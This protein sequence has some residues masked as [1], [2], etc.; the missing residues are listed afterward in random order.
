MISVLPYLIFDFNLIYPLFVLFDCR[1]Y[2]T[3]QIFCPR[4]YLSLLLNLIVMYTLTQNIHPLLV[5]FDCH[6][7]F[8]DLIFR[9]QLYLSSPPWLDCHVYLNPIHPLLVKFDCCVYFNRYSSLPVHFSSTWLFSLSALTVNCYIILSK[10]V[11][12]VIPCHSF[13]LVNGII[14]MDSCQ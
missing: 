8:T 1:L 9:P 13:T 4:C 11:Q 3:N 6:V 14:W 7:Y 5:K 2:L 10:Y 12:L